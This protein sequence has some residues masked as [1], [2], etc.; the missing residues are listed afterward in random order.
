[1]AG[2]GQ[3]PP[4]NLKATFAEC[5]LLTKENVVLI[6]TERFGNSAD[7]VKTQIYHTM[8]TYTKQ[9]SCSRVLFFSPN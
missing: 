3:Q 9:Y 2:G 1:M 7:F 8:G 6:F 4:K 5:F